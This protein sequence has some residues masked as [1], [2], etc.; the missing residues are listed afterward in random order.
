MTGG[1]GYIGS[2]VCKALARDGFQPV[3]YD[4]LSRGHEWAVRWGV[5]ERGDILDREHLAS[6][7]VRHR[8][9]IVVHC[10]AFAYVQ[11]SMQ[12]PAMYYENNVLGSLRLLEAMRDT[13]LNRIVFSST[14]ATYGIARAPRVIEDH[15]QNPVSVYGKTKK[16]VEQMLGD[17]DQAHG[18]RHIILRYFNAAGADA[19]GEIGES[20]DPEPHIVPSVLETAAGRRPEIVING[21]DY[22]TE[23]GTCVRDFIHVS[24]IADAHVLAC[25]HLLRNHG[26]DVFNLGAQSGYSLKQIIKTASAVTGRTIPYVVRDRRP[27]DPP[28]VICDAGKAMRVLGWSPKSSGLES[29]L[30]SAWRWMQKAP[31]R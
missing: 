3:V 6:V 10:A 31:S 7:I 9:E 24:D 1:A 13:G 30:D 27:G 2:H 26:S 8:P 17:F 4:N 28:S 22:E 25:Q 21:G 18:I 16:V 12:N 15:E 29:M 23:D 5:L 11:E 14:C 20:H 19:D